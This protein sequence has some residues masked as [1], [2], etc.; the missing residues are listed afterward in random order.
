MSVA[1]VDQDVE[2]GQE[3]FGAERLSKHHKLRIEERDPQNPG[4]K[5]ARVETQTHLDR[6]LKRE[7]IT[8]EQGEAGRIYFLSAYYS[9][10]IP[11]P[12]AGNQDRV[13]GARFA[14]QEAP[15]SARQKR[16]KAI[17]ALGRELFGIAEAVIVDDRAAEAWAIEHGEH[18]RAGI[19][20]LRVALTTLARHYGL[21]R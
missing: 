6:Y 5:R 10:A 20:V 15:V 14:T 8:V 11:R 9:G 3:D 4:K 16:T 12:A 18:P 13:D 7:S 19:A 21:I 2:S 17:A 1:T